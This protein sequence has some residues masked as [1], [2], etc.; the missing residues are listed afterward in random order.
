MPVMHNMAIAL[1]ERDGNVALGVG[2]GGQGIGRRGVLEN[3]Y[4]MIS[5][6]RL[7][8]SVILC[9]G[10]NQRQGAYPPPPARTLV[11]GSIG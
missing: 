11:K 6:Y 3:L 10:H 7:S 4:S 1:I 5:G 8:L 2:V 9:V